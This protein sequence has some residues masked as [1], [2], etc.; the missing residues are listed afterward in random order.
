[1]RVAA[2]PGPYLRSFRCVDDVRVVARSAAS[3]QTVPADG[4]EMRGATDA[5]M[6]ESA[7]CSH[8]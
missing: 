5:R 7:R 2:C 3:T 1:M 4:I 6:A 8:R